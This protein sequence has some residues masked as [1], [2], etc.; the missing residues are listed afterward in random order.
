M[1]GILR[2]MG[3]GSMMVTGDNWGTAMAIARELGIERGRVFAESLPEDK[4]RIV[5]E[6]Q[7]C[8]FT[9]PCNYAF[10][11]LACAN[12]YQ[13]MDLKVWPLRSLQGFEL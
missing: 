4:A 13:F 10:F 3:V 11:L 8:L 6:I 2:S 1:I 7:V 5:K 9:S 12:S